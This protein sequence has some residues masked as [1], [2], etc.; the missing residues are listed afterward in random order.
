MNRRLT[1]LKTALW[2]FAGALAVLTVVRFANGL[3]ATTNLSD[4]APWGLWI[5]FD[6]MAGVALAAGGFVLA[7]TVY[8]FGLEKYRPLVRPAI[9]T[10]FLGYVAVA[11]GLLYDL[12]LPWHIWHPMVYW[13][14]HSVLFEV[15]MCVMTYLT[16][17][18]LE[19]A[20]VALEHPAFDRPLFRRL[21]GLLKKVTLPLVIAGIVLSTL[22]QSSLGSLFLIV[23]HRL[24]PLW[25]SPILYVL[26]FVSAVGLGMMMVTLESLLS[27]FFFKHAVHKDLLSGLG[28]AAAWVLGVYAV[29]RVGDLLVRGVLPAALDGSWA[30]VLFVVELSACSI[31][32][33]ILL[34]IR[35]VR[36][37]VAGLSV[38]SVLTVLGMIG[39]RAN[40]AILAIRRPEEMPYFPSLAEFGVSL[41]V[42]SVA[43]LA[44]LFLVE[45]LRVY[46]EAARTEPARPV[47]AAST[48]HGLAPHAWSAPRRYSFAF[49][50]AAALSLLVLPRSAVLGNQPE[51]TSVAP[52]RRV[53]GSRTRPDAGGPVRLRL[54]READAE[55]AD[56]L[57][58]DGNRDGTAVLFDHHGHS[59]RLGG[60]SS[61]AA[62]HHLSLP[63]D[64]HS[65]CW[66]CHRDQYEPTDLFRH[67]AHA[68][69]LGG[70]AGCAECH[71]EASKPKTRE[72]SASC[73][74]CHADLVSKESRVSP[75]GG[76]WK[77]A[78][79]YMDAM[80]G[81]CITCH[82]DERKKKPDGTPAGLERCGT[83]HDADRAGQLERMKPSAVK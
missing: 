27:A 28:K 72:T 19:F 69:H 63:L 58:I 26:F 66:E 23:P 47:P 68:R 50:A 82:E 77:P 22:H 64:R 29:L 76:R 49:V 46:G 74:A 65:S 79:G 43:A 15:A 11:V 81:L 42:V 53:A 78:P 33:A 4:A 21:L 35:R 40:V 55:P 48:I 1:R 30:T 75:P 20:P 70:N 67:D 25:Y 51:G 80:H 37:S 18:A 7:G 2:A 38:A 32:P 5:A 59:E 52:P 13:Q 73:E 14:H 10:A 83:C 12:G 31:V 36:T 71:A 57:M 61:C 24:L 54:A 16:V 44:F 9:L 56:L 39:T 8:I 60:D 41:G 17:L 3:G 45:R 62:C 6:V 34:S